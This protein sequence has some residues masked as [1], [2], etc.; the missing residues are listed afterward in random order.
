[1]S[2]EIYVAVTI[3]LPYIQH[4]G[5]MLCSLFENNKARKFHIFVLSES[6]SFVQARR[7]RRL[8]R[9][10]NATLVF[11][12]IEVKQLMRLKV[13]LHAS[14]ANYYRL[15][16][17]N[18]LPENLSKVLYLDSDIII[19]TNIDELW[20]TDINEHYLAATK[21]PSYD[22]SY[23]GFAIEDNYFNSGVMLIN[24]EKWRK[25]EVGRLVIEFVK[26][27]PDKIKFWDQDGLN[28]ILKD[29]WLQISQKWNQTSVVFEGNSSTQASVIH[30]TGSLKPWNYH[31]QHPLRKEYFYYIKKTPWKNFHFKEDMLFHKAKQLIKKT[32]N[33]LSGKTVFEVY[34]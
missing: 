7:L 10:Y 25:N 13:D 30:Y 21:E 15:L 31:C 2:D 6:F 16:L 17:P 28:F 14:P 34:A 20:Q 11:I 5:V 32:I 27:N 29:K 19:K 22:C 33:R 12:E 3:D 23:L 8:S 24:L 4:L 9:M 1:M 26:Q 18:L